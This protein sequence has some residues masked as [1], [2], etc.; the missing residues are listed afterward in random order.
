MLIALLAL[1]QN[2][3]SKFS[4]MLYEVVC[5]FG[6]NR[7][8]MYRIDVPCP[9][10]PS[11][12]TYGVTPGAQ[13]TQEKER[14]TPGALSSNGISFWR[15]REARLLRRIPTVFCVHGHSPGRPLFRKTL[16]NPFP[17]KQG[18]KT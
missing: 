2:P 1:V 16:Q 17:W 5:G 11:P 13:G 14:K 12:H 10:F 3:F 9:I 7:G 18:C 8:C 4:G 15:R 6:A